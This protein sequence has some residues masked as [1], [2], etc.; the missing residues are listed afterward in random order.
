MIRKKFLKT[1]MLSVC[2]SALSTGMVFAKS[3]DNKTAEVTAQDTG[4]GS[5]QNTKADS[6]RDTKEESVQDAKTDS[7]LQELQN[8]IDQYVFG[9]HFDEIKKMG[10]AVTHT[11][12]IDNYI[13]IGITPYSEENADYLYGIFGSENVKVI[14]GEEAVLF[15]TD[16]GTASDAAKEGNVNGAGEA[17]NAPVTDTAADKKSSMLPIVGIAGVAALLGGAVAMSQKKKTSR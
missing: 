10:F 7:D 3:A 12:P 17:E 11:G 9:D 4:A 1:V 8:K 2:I 13:E 16:G 14:E 5:Y 15:T 6:S